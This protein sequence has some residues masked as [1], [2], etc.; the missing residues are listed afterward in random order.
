MSSLPTR[1]INPI[2]PTVVSFGQVAAGTAPN[3]IP[4]RAVCQGT[5]RTYHEADR[6]LLHEAITR[7]AESVAAGRGATGRVRFVR[8]GPALVNDPGLVRRTDRHLAGI[9][10]TVAESPFRSCGSDD[11]AEYGAATA[12]LMCFV[13][14]GRINGV[15][16]HHGA[17]LPGRDAL[18]LCAQALACGYVAAVESLQGVSLRSGGPR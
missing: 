6:A 18:E 4:D 12:S 1:L 9:G 15:G 7:T 14:T 3:V 13:G 8:G 16:L 11:F 17:Y 5:I 10:L 2:H